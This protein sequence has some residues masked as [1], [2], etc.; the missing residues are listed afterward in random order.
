MVGDGGGRCNPCGGVPYS[1][2][3]GRVFSPACVH[4]PGVLIM[5]QTAVQTAKPRGSQTETR[6][7][8]VV[9]HPAFIPEQSDAAARQ[10]LFSY[11]IRITN[12]SAA[13]AKLLSR[14][15]V[16]VDAHGER[17]EVRGPG[18]VGQ[19]P[20]L[21]PGQSFEYS[22]FS[23]LRTPWGTMEGDYQFQRDDGSIFDVAI[24]RFYLV[25]DEQGGRS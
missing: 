19:Q 15:W 21:E 1:P 8:R 14:H 10:F 9:V 22:S 12:T 5:S 17:E 20:R 2:S 25:S 23:Q 6:G 3:S 7:V 16:I 11:R 13:P 18:V 24:G 4:V